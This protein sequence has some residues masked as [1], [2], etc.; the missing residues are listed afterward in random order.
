MIQNL[1]HFSLSPNSRGRFHQQTCAAFFREQKEN[2][3]FGA[4]NEKIRQKV[5]QFKLEIW[6]FNR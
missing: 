5:H 3:F 2:P 4:Q 6:S 1:F